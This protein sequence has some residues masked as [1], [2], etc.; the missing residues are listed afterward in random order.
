MSNASL[1]QGGRVGAPIARRS[2]GPVCD[3][4][5][6]KGSP[7]DHSSRTVDH[8]QVGAHA[9][10]VS[11]VAG[12]LAVVFRSVG[13]GHDTATRHIILVAL[14]VVARAMCSLEDSIPTH[15]AAHPFAN[16]PGAA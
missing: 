7:W 1:A 9:I 5:E 3:D 15:L 12:P 16:V 2:L 4:R 13:I 14:A 10:A 11:P 8:I 6:Q